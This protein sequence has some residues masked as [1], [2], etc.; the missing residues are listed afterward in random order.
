MKNLEKIVTPIGTYYGF[1]GD[2]ISKQLHKYGAHQ[3]NELAMLLSI[4]REG[5]VVLDIGAN[6]GTFSIPLSKKV[7]V[8]GDVYGFEGDPDI[9]SVL[10][11]NGTYICM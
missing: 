3:R 2:L 7:G 4:V 11:K 1:S 10:K 9:F 6:I 5:D 8:N